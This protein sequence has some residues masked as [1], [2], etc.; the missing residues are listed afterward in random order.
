MNAVLAGWPAAAASG[1]LAP[2][3]ARVAASLFAVIAISD[4]LQLAYEGLE[5]RV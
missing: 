5:R 3:V 4:T 1:G 2:R